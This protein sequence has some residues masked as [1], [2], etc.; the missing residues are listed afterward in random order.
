MDEDRKKTEERGEKGRGERERAKE[1]QK[2]RG[3]AERAWREQGDR[4]VF[5]L[6]FCFVSGFSTSSLE[7]TRGF[8]P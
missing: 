7:F 1:R 6:S 5:V 8:P 4:V 2:E 3:R